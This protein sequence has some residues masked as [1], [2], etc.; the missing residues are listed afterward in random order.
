[1]AKTNFPLSFD[2]RQ[3]LTTVAA[4]TASAILPGAEPAN[5]AQIV[6]T[7]HRPCLGRRRRWM[8]NDRLEA[9]GKSGNLG[10]PVGE[11]RGRGYEKARLTR[12]PGLVL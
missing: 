10:G 7:V 5:S 4:V 12:V 11:Q 2:R 1:M 3:L 9:W 6:G 8:N